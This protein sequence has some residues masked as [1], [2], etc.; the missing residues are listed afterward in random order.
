MQQHIIDTLGVQADIDLDSEIVRR[1]NFMVDYLHHTRANGLVLGISGGVDSTVGGR[2]CQMAVEQYRRVNPD[3]KGKFWGVRLPYHVQ[4]DADDAMAAIEFIEPDE[5]IELQIGSATDAIGEAFTAALG[6]EPTDYNLGNVKARMRM[7][8]QYAIAGQ[9]NALVVGSDQA[10]ESVTGFFTKFG[11]GAADLMPLAGLTKTQVRNMGT[12]LGA[13]E[14]L[15]EKVPTADL[16][17]DN[18]GQ[19]DEDELGMT[20]ANIDAY[21]LGQSIPDEAREKLETTYKRSEHKRR[22]PVRP[23]DTWWE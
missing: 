9:Y 21:L 6:E 2:L 17:T 10:A 23:S 11:D 3:W 4:G 14:R 15:I 22:L 19:T 18:P 13:S 7:V 1:V 5:D 16:L 20:Y 8:A 12:R